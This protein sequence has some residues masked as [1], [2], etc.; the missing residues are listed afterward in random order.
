MQPQAARFRTSVTTGQRSGSLP[1]RTYSPR[2]AFLSAAEFGWL[3]I[4][5]LAGS[6]VGLWLMSLGS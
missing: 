6:A 3:V 5:L 1:T 2:E 4:W